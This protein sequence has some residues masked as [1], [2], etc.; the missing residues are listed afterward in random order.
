M[1]IGPS[2][3][4]SSPGFPKAPSIPTSWP[5]DY[6]DGLCHTGDNR[7]QFLVFADE[8]LIFINELTDLREQ[9]CW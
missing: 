4:H 5:G 1:T 7:V 6:L 9:C 3:G 8:R 2:L